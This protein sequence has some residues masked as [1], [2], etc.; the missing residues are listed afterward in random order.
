MRHSNFFLYFFLMLFAGSC[1]TSST[2]VSTKRQFFPKSETKR[3][4]EFFKKLLF[5]DEAVYTL[6]GSKPMTE[7]ILHPE[8]LEERMHLQSEA[9]KKLSKSEL[10]ELEASSFEYDENYWFEETWAMWEETLKTLPMKRYLFVERTIGIPPDMQKNRYIYF[11]NIAETA[12]VLQQHYALFRECVG[13][14]FD[15]LSVVFD[16]KKSESPFWNAIWGREITD[17]TVCL[18]GILFG[19]GFENSYPFSWH[20]SQPQSAETKEFITSFLK[21]GTSTKSI[22]ALKRFDPPTSFLLPGYIS[23]SGYDSHKERYKQEHDRI[24]QI[25]MNADLIDCTMHQLLN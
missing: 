6:F 15:P 25:Y 10:A 18:M 12:K 19:Y 4:E 9:L 14:D 1:S 7:I 11:I 16:A 24:R 8:T 5:L 17:K 3:Y 2:R 23:F 20:F 22:S 13:F 21:L